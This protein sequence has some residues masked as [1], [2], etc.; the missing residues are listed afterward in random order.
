VSNHIIKQ[1]VGLSSTASS[2]ATG[3][4]GKP[5]QGFPNFSALLISRGLEIAAFE[6]KTE[7]WFWKN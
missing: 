5:I 6:A 3:D 4:K 2:E 1:R 7:R